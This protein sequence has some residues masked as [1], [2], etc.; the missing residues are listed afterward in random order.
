MGKES[1]VIHLIRSRSSVMIHHEQI[2]VSQS[3]FDSDLEKVFP[4][5]VIMMFLRRNFLCLKP[6][7]AYERLTLY[8]TQRHD[9]SVEEVHNH[10]H[11]AIYNWISYN[12][13]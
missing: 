2:K 3:Y 4:L 13:S 10:V 11:K 6:W 5:K 9:S 12:V 8:D 1:D 7:I